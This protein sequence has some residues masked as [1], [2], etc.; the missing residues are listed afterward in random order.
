MMANASGLTASPCPP[1]LHIEYNIELGLEE[2]YRGR[3]RSIVIP[4]Y[5]EKEGSNGK[6]T[7]KQSFDVNIERG[8]KE[9]AKVRFSQQ[10]NQ[11]IGHI[12][13][14][15]AFHIKEKPHKYYVRNGDDLEYKHRVN[16]WKDYEADQYELEVYTI[17]KRCLTYHDVHI[18]D[19]SQPT[20]LKDL[21]MP[22]TENPEKKGNLIIMRY[23]LKKSLFETV[24]D[25]FTPSPENKSEE[26]K[27]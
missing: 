15:V 14:D 12:P 27:N 24:R 1:H 26:T 5:I 10:G 13:S 4:R 11:L 6:L 23:N 3:K 8:W 7:S 18:P 2:L 9:G 20:T 19:L 25:F 22:L 17:D 16:I 21:G